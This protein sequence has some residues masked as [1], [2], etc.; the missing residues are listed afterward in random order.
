MA[1]LL[2]SKWSLFSDPQFPHLCN[3]NGGG[4]LVA[5]SCLLFAT[6]WAV[7]CQAS[8]YMGFSRH[9]YWSGLL[10]P[11]PRDLSNPRIKPGS[12]VYCR[13]ILYQQ[14]H[15]G[16]H[17]MGIL[18]SKVTAGLNYT[19]PGPRPQEVLSILKPAFFFFSL[20]SRSHTKNF[21]SLYKRPTLAAFFLPLSWDLQRGTSV[22]PYTV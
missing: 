15:Q 9:Q 2:T 22:C 10:F 1:S 16:S 14:S 6:P 18:L 5:E 12:P 20:G 13:W 4:G 19:Y 7:V 17:V 3:G 21:I 8:M 11:S